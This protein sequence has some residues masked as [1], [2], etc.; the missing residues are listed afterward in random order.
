ML[1][2]VT[3]PKCEKQSNVP[4]NQLGRRIRC[5]GCQAI[6]VVS[7]E[8]DGPP[9]RQPH[10]IVTPPPL[11][12]LST[13]TDEPNDEPAT[14]DAPPAFGPTASP[15]PLGR[16]IVMGVIALLMIGGGIFAAMYFKK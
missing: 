10:R 9:P 12:G 3:C 11:P 14:D 5:A 7:H 4:E 1:V 15:S 6:F 8:T 16:W 2:V 13:P